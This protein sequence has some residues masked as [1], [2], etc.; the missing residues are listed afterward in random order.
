M[1]G[2][3]IDS[4]ENGEISVTIRTRAYPAGIAVRGPHRVK[5]RTHVL[6]SICID[7]EES[8]KDSGPDADVSISVRAL[9]AGGNLLVHNVHVDDLRDLGIDTSVV[10]G[11]GK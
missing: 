3:E 2:L 4:V 10:I 7:D 9:G 6:A 11:K 5:R 1:S 8:V